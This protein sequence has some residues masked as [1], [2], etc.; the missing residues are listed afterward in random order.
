MTLD[1]FYGQSGELFSYFRIPKALFQDSRFRQLSTDA[2]TLYGILLDRMSLSV[3]NGWMDK[4]GRVYIIYTV[5]EVQESLCCAEHKAVKLFRE[6]E[7]IDLIER[8]RRGLGRPSL[9]Y[10]KDFTTGLSKTHNLNCAN[11]NSGVAQSAVQERP[12]PQANKTD[13]NKTEMNKPDPIHSGD[14]REQLEDYFYQALEVELLL[15]LFPDDEDALNQLSQGVGR[16]LLDAYI[17]VGLLDEKLDVLMLSFLYFNFLLQ[18]LRFRFQLLLFRLIALAHH[19]EPLVAEPSCGVVLIGLDEQPLQFCN[20][21]LIALQLLEMDLNLLAALQP[22]LLAHDG[23]EVVL[24]V[25]DMIRYHLDVVQH[26]T[27]QNRLSDVVCAALLLVLPV[28]GTIEESILRLVVVGGTVIHLCAAV[29]AIHQTGEHAGSSAAGHAVALLADLLHLF[30]HIVLDDALMGVR[31]H[32]LIFQ[33]VSPLFFVPDGI[34]EGLEIHRAA[35]VLPAFQN[36][37]HRA[38]RP[39]TG[40]FRQ[41]VSRFLS[42]LLLVSGR[43]QHLIRSQLIGNLGRATALHAHGKDPLDHLCGLRV[44]DPVVRV[45][46]VSTTFHL[47]LFSSSI[48]LKRDITFPLTFPNCSVNIKTSPLSVLISVALPKLCRSGGYLLLSKE[49]LQMKKHT[50]VLSLLVTLVLALGLL[51]MAAFAAY[52][53]VYDVSFQLKDGTVIDKYPVSYVS[54]VTVPA[55]CDVENWHCEALNMDVAPGETVLPIDFG[56]DKNVVF[57][58]DTILPESFTLNFRL[59]NGFD[60]GSRVLYPN[61]FMSFFT[62]PTVDGASVN[63]AADKDRVAHKVTLASGQMFTGQDLDFDYDWY[64]K[65]PVLN[66][67]LTSEAVRPDDFTVK[68]IDNNGREVSKQTVNAL[69]FFAGL[70]VPAGTWSCPRQNNAVVSEGDYISGQTLDLDYTWYGYHPVV[71]FHAN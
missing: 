68:F 30:K 55:Y 71:E 32:G 41:R 39:F 65:N 29:G 62:V 1:Y 12:K 60:A 14:I 6:L 18:S 56:E 54:S 59:P 5:R 53:N 27:L 2:R 15:R 23:H 34:G 64:E 38:V 3:K 36:F 28:E 40:I 67:D 63:W 45:V 50:R 13:K 8:K 69:N 52:P 47:N 57:V 17:L 16:Q 35:G 61:N 70:T 58:A 66:F 22:H 21:L 20:P 26:Q 4:Q 19:V 51:P 42:L 43:C 9:I 44:D 7:Q 37:D 46:T 10:V 31:E 48:N 24:M 33:R 49:E 11:S 25:Q